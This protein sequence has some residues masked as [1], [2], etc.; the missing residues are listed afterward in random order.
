MQNQYSSQLT[1]Q[2]MNP[3]SYGLTNS[4]GM[5]QPPNSLGYTQP[6]PVIP[7][8][9]TRDFFETIKRGDIAE[10]NDFIGNYNKDYSAV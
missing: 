7:I 4:L 9:L 6:N 2:K 3:S 8:G 10:I 1:Q 5:M